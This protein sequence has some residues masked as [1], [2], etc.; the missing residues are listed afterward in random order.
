M[1]H[2]PIIIRIAFLATVAGFFEAKAQARNLYIIESGEKISIALDE[3]RKLAFFGENMDVVKWTGD[4]T[5]SF[6][7]DRISLMGFE[8]GTNIVLPT[9][10]FSTVESKEEAG[11][12]EIYDI[13]GKLVRLHPFSGFSATI[14]LS[15]L[16]KGVYLVK[17]KNNVR[18]II[19][20]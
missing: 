9:V 19:K 12:L 1:K 6:D 18:K 3:I 14:D 13:T 2:W 17:T 15:V 20:N 11:T 4:E 7:I 8:Y 10:D 16:N 5:L